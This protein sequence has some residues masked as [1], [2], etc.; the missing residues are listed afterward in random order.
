LAIGVETIE[1]DVIGEEW[2]RLCRDEECSLRRTSGRFQIDTAIPLA[3][4]RI[5]VGTAEGGTAF[6]DAV[7]DVEDLPRRLESL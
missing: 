6:G 5:V 3:G 2:D 4:E 1:S 7:R